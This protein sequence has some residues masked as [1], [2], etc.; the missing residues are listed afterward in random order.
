M[1]DKLSS[2]GQIITFY[3]YKGGTGRSMA[4]ANVACLLAQQQNIGDNVLMIDWDLEAPGLH[5]FFHGRFEYSIYKSGD[6]P[7]GRLGLIDLF[8]EVKSLLEK[9]ASEGDIPEDFFDQINIDKYIVKTDLPSLFFMPAGEF[10]DGLYSVRVNEFDWADFFN[11]YPSAV[12]QF[13]QYL[14]RKF[15]YVLIDSRTGYT[16]I[17]GIC[18]S[19][20]PEKLVGVFTPNRQSLS[21]I[22]ELIRR[23]TDYRKQSDDLHPLMVF[24]LPSRIENAENKLQKEWRF[25]NPNLEVEGYQRQLEAVLMDVYGLLECDLTEYFDEYQLQYTPKYSYGEELAVLSDRSEDRLSLAR[26][27][28]NF[29]QKVISDETPWEKTQDI[30][31]A[32]EREESK[33]KIDKLTNPETESRNKTLFQMLVPTLGIVSIFI[34]LFVASFLLNG[35]NGNFLGLATWTASPSMTPICS[36][37]VQLSIPEGFVITSRLFVILYDPRYT[38]DQFL[39]LNTGEETQDIPYFIRKT[40]PSIMEPGDR[41]VVFQLGY[42]SFEDAIVTS[43]SSFV[44][45]PQ[46]LNTPSPVETLTPLPTA[47]VSTPGLVAIATENFIRSQSTAR[48]STEQANQSLYDC[49]KENWNASIRQTATAW[50]ITQVAESAD[51]ASKINIDFE[52]FMSAE[53]KVPFSTNELDL[54]GVYF[55]LNFATV[56]F[57]SEC[58]NYSECVIM[59]IDDLS[60]FG[61]NN[62]DNLPI[63]LDHVSIYSVLQD[64]IDI[65]QPSCMALQEYWNNEFK[66]FSAGDIVYLNGVRVEQ[67]L[68]NAL[69]R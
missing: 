36:P 56:V 30:A 47:N 15:K 29:A 4:L 16:D 62:P 64:C 3:S 38:G 7:R 32:T 24:P 9:R 50:E 18:T 61:E 22:V 35:R 12:T 41:V 57:E 8:Y 46:I 6:L 65:N 63:D 34:M 25:G 67:N 40:I 31:L 52:K 45:V 14:R 39:E 20:M 43:Q 58:Q 49:E 42:S 28:E 54:G 51:I 5:Q 10:D 33:V 37:D 60:V 13:A 53:T 44:A 26:S 11:K 55:G 17:S 1:K 23:A 48:A 27:F 21:G 69:G 19:I 68:L 66:R 2:S 59:L